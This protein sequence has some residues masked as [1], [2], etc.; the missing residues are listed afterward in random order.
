M[1]GVSA[2]IKQAMVGAQVCLSIWVPGQNQKI[3]V[4]TNNKFYK[5]T[6]N[7]TLSNTISNDLFSY[8]L[9]TVMNT[10]NEKQSFIDHAK[11]LFG[12]QRTFTEREREI[13]DRVTK[14]DSTPI[15]INTFDLL[16]KFKNDS[17]IR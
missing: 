13:Y 11:S 3:T 5:S 14:E 17:G 7:A 4:D 2:G 6:M 1:Q 16:R 8:E 12:E 15:G 9:K 10:H